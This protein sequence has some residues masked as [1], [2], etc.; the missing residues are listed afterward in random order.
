MNGEEQYTTIEL[1]DPHTE[2]RNGNSGKKIRRLLDAGIIEYHGIIELR[3]SHDDECPQ[4]TNPFSGCICDPY[5]YDASGKR[6]D[7]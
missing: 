5:I 6:I 2:F 1:I 3:I 7:I 4:L